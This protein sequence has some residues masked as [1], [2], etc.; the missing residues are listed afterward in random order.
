MDSK[1]DTETNDASS[2]YRFYVYGYYSIVLF[3][4]L[5]CG[6]EGGGESIHKMLT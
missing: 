1:R 6:L 4:S 2:F 3:F 5:P